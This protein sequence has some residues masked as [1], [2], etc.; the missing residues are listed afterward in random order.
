MSVNFTI[1][2]PF[3]VPTKNHKIKGGKVSIRQLDI[4]AD[5]W[6][7]EPYSEFAEKKG[8]Y[9]FANA[10]TRG[11]TPIYVGL[12]NRTFK[13]EC[14]AIAKKT[15]LNDFLAGASKTGP[16]IYF[17]VAGKKNCCEEIDL[18][19]TFL[20]QKCKEANENLLNVKKLSK[21][22]TIKSFHGDKS[23]ANGSVLEFKKCLN[24]K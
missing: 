3:P 6:K 12:T 19:E 21:K 1:H 4:K 18:C 7:Q 22:F 8:C 20:I 13:E 17:V 11:S 5:L 16:Q 10:V 15:M 14:F 23:K 24:I 2:G 9:V